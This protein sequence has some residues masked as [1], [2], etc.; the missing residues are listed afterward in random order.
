MVSGISVHFDRT[1][2]EEYVRDKVKG[3]TKDIMDLAKV[4]KSQP[5]AAYAAYV[6]GLSSRWSYLLRTVPEVGDL[7][8][9]L[10]EALH[11]HFIPALT[12]HPP[13]SNIK[14]DLLALLVRLGGLGICNPTTQPWDSFHSS[15]RITAQLVALIV[16][17]NPTETVDHNITKTAKNDVKKMNRQ[18]QDEQAHSVYDQLTPQLKR[19]TDLSKEKGSSAWLSVLPFGEHGFHLHKGQ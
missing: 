12:G 1:F 4:A 5:H 15:E 11:Q 7:L 6:H 10:E 3:W 8:Q 9:P 2:T 18:K 13:C 19:C 14:R 16:L 17:Q